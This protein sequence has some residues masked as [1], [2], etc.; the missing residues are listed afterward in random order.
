M[1]EE[2][3]ALEPLGVL[4]VLGNGAGFIRRRETGYTPGRRDFYVG[5]KLIRKFH[6]RS[7]DE[8]TGALG[9]KPRSGKSAPH[10]RQLKWQCKPYHEQ[11]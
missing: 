9:K 7:G 4:E 5:P 8:I 3:T 2:T 6:L 10:F 11:D 1:S